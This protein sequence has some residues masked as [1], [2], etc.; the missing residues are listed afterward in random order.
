M[1]GLPLPQSFG[2][3]DAFATAV[4]KA[5][6]AKENSEGRKSWLTWVGS[7]NGKGVELKT[8]SR[9]YPQILT[10]DGVRHGGAM[11]LRPTAFVELLTEA[12]S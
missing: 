9:S 5:I 10:V 6:L 3:P 2:S 1:D 12:T 4:S 8:Y 7:V 11:D